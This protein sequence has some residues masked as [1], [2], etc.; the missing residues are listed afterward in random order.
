MPPI[1]VTGPVSTLTYDEFRRQQAAEYPNFR[2]DDDLFGSWLSSLTGIHIN[3]LHLNKTRIDVGQ[4]LK[5]AAITAGVVFAGPALL[6]AATKA[7]PAIVSA[8]SAGGSAAKAALTA[9][10][11]KPA[12]PTYSLAP[13]FNPAAFSAPVSSP[14]TALVPVTQ[15]QMLAPVNVTASPVAGISPAILAAGAVVALF[16]ISQ[17][18]RRH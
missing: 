6:A 18:G 1:V 14:S 16:L 10:G 2:T 9:L 8:L 7:T 13:G 17:S 15:A 12:A 3:P 5:T 11:A 4:L